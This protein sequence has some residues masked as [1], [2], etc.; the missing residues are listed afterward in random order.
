MDN[1]SSKI[2]SNNVLPVKF[3]I[4]L[5]EAKFD[6]KSEV[7]DCFVLLTRI[8]MDGTND[9]YGEAESVEIKK[10]RLDK[11]SQA[12]CEYLSLIKIRNNIF[13]WNFTH[14]KVSSCSQKMLVL[15]VSSVCVENMFAKVSSNLLELPSTLQ[16]NI[17]NVL[18]SPFL[19][20]ISF[21]LN[22]CYT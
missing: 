21:S 7:R 14:V 11:F 16:C 9:D 22:F 20:H 15:R 2:E 12:D 3:S 8:K 19:S 1:L 18:N 5:S 6:K 13:K 4:P 10:K 17:S